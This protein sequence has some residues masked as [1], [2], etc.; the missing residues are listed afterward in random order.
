MPKRKAQPSRSSHAHP[1]KA[2]RLDGPRIVEPISLATSAKSNASV[3]VAAGAAAQSFLGHMRPPAFVAIATLGNSQDEVEEMKRD[4]SARAQL[5]P[6]FELLYRYANAGI[7][8]PDQVRGYNVHVHEAKI[9]LEA[10]K[11]R[12]NESQARLAAELDKSAICDDVQSIIRVSPSIAAAF[13]NAKR[14]CVPRND[15]AFS[16]WPT[17]QPG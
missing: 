17:I 6:A 7:A 15:C 8:S 14:W 16:S 3:K 9:G 5:N 11:R 2:R 10:R 1:S 4:L 13:A 12:H